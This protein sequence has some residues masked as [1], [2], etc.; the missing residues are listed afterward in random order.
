MEQFEVGQKVIGFTLGKWEYGTYVRAGKKSG[1]HFI[2]VNGEE[3]KI[4]Q[5]ELRYFID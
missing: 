5:N 4:I 1:E 3:R 2:L